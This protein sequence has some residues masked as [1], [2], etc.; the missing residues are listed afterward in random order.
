M[1]RSLR[2][3]VLNYQLVD[4]LLVLPKVKFTFL[5]VFSFSLIR[6]LQRLF[7][8]ISFPLVFLPSCLS[9]T[10]ELIVTHRLIIKEL[11]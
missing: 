11:V 9:Y 1:L 2:R 7:L 6:F 10:E 3:R 8:G 4:N 5:F